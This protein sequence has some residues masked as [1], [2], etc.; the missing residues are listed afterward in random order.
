[1]FDSD[2]SSIICSNPAQRTFLIT[3][4]TCMYKAGLG[5]RRFQ[6]PHCRSHQQPLVSLHYLSEEAQLKVGN[7][8]SY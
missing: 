7:R 1:M 2:T 6:W 3:N 4:P 8:Q 5:T